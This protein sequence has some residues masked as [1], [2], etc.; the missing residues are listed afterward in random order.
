MTTNELNQPENFPTLDG[1]PVELLEET[2]LVAMTNENKFFCL[3]VEAFLTQFVKSPKFFFFFNIFKFSCS[4][5]EIIGGLDKLKRKIV[6]KICERFNILREVSQI[7]NILIFSQ[8]VCKHQTG[9]RHRRHNPDKVRAN[10][11]SPMLF[12]RADAPSRIGK[13]KDARTNAIQKNNLQA[14]HQQFRLLLLFA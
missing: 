9:N 8:K 5:K 13:R 3:E 6:H 14:Q 4:P 11:Y 1:E 10:H 12:D 7:M 2:L